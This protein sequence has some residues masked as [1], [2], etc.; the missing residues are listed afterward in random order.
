MKYNAIYI[1]WFVYYQNS[2]V[3]K[4]PDTVINSGPSNDPWGTS[5]L[6]V[7]MR[8]QAESS[9]EQEVHVQSWCVPDR[10]ETPSTRCLLTVTR[11]W[12]KL[13]TL[14]SG[15]VPQ[16]L[17][18]QRERERERWPDNHLENSKRDYYSLCFVD[19]CAWTTHSDAMY[20]CG[21]SDMFLCI[22][23]KMED[24]DKNN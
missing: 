23:L 3:S 8:K 11:V 9:V 14:Q 7:S 13:L 16:L 5:W 17:P 12:L 21:V 20:V 2:S 19:N 4:L 24:M 10:T 18:E 22:F 15:S 6:S 1:I